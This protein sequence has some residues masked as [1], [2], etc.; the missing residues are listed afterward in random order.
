M[1]IYMYMDCTYMDVPVFF[2]IFSDFEICSLKKNDS[3]DNR[4]Q[5][6]SPEYGCTVMAWLFGNN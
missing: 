5:N 3:K 4:G 2:Q 1:Q 6:V